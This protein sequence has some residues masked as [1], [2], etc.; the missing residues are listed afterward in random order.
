MMPSGGNTARAEAM[1]EMDG[2][3]HSI[4]TDPQ[5]RS[6]I[7]AA[8]SEPLGDLD[9]ANL[10]EIR[11]DWRSANALPADLVQRQS[12]ANATC[13]HAWREQRPANDWQGFLENFR[14]VLKCSRAQAAFLSSET[15]LK[16][17]DALM[18]FYEPGMTS[19]KL[20]VLFDDLLTWL[21]DLVRKVRLKQASQNVLPPVGPFSRAAQHA[22]GLEVMTLLG[23][24]FNAGRL[25]ESAHPFCGGV[26]A[27]GVGQPASH[28]ERPNSA[29][30][31]T[32][33][34][35]LPSLWSRVVGVGQPV[36][37]AAM[38]SCGC[39]FHRSCI[40]YSVAAPCLLSCNLGV[41]QPNKIQSLADMRA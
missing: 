14:A 27:I 20:D 21:P 28:T 25:D 10:R 33:R 37:A 39:T 15:G 1:A 40:S 11:R 38:C 5:L 2:L 9:K 13:E 41:G 7:D 31:G 26:P 8:E 30:I 32:F 36:S 22:V 16:P 12:L 29:L 35:S 19:E 4:R 17:Y 6:Y 24:D 3:L 34:H 18:D 23:F